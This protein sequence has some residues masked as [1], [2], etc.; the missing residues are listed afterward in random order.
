MSLTLT[1]G[2]VDKTSTFYLPGSTGDVTFSFIPGTRGS[3]RLKVYDVLGAAGYRPAIDDTLTLADGATTVFSGRIDDVDEQPLTDLDTG[4]VT[5]LTASDWSAV[6]G[7]VSY[8]VTYAAGSTLKA[9][10]TDLVTNKLSAFG[11]TLD[12]AQ[13][14]GPTFSTAVTFSTNVTVNEILNR[15]TALT[16]WLWR[17]TPTKTL[18]MIAPAATSC[19]Y[20]LSDADTDGVLG[21][22]SYRQSRALNYANTIVLTC[23]TAKQVLK[24]EP[25]TGDGVASSWTLTYAA[26]TDAGGFIVSRGYVT[27][28]GVNKTVG[29]YG[30]T[31]VSYQ[32][33]ASNNTLYRTAGPL[34]AGV[35]ISF[36]H[37]VQ[38]PFTVTYAN[39]AEVTAHGTY[40]GHYDAPDI[41]DYTEG[42]TMATALARQTITQPKIVTVKT[43]KGI[44]YPGQSIALTFAERNLSGTFMITGVDVSSAEDGSLEYTL[45]CVSGAELATSWLDFY[46]ETSTGTGSG[47]GGTVSGGA[48]V[49][50]GVAGSGTAGKL[51]KWATSSSLTDSIVSES[52]TTATVAGTLAATTFSGSGASLTSV[53]AGQLTGTIPAATL[54]GRSLA[55]L[56]TRS[57]GDLSSGNLAYARMP[58]GAG[59]W[60]A[61]PTISGTLTVS[62]ISASGD[63][64]LS[65]AGVIAA[66]SIIP[67]LTDTYDLGRYDRLWNQSYISQMN[68]LVFAKTT[69]TL[70]GGYSSIGKNA[71]SFA[72]DVA[73]AATTIDF[74][75]AMTVGDFVLV[76]AHDTGGTIKAEYLQ[77]GT[78]VSGTTYNVT[79]DLAAA[80]VTDP[81]WASGTPY[82]VLGTTNDGRI[83]LFAYDGK[84]RIVFTQQGATYNAQSDRGIIGNLNSYFGYAT[85]VYG[86]AFGDAAAANITIDPTNGFRVR[87]G[88]TTY[89][90][91][92]SSVFTV[93]NPSGKRIGWDGT[94]LTLVSDYVT[95][96]N[97]G[98]ALAPD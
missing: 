87:Q 75:Q 84:P 42:V 18:L 35:A 40:E 2:G 16:G 13:A 56:G 65:P 41:E 21:V 48:T 73:S 52:G 70:F 50:S 66:K 78:L 90:Q 91:L 67:A 60:S 62:T 33:R 45:T 51:A 12:A 97:T 34:G 86:A 93:G 37:Q 68:A 19:G 55:D 24:D 39:S 54:A 27:E 38:L 57:A 31:S 98:I 79:R 15:F 25:F 83:D 85:D 26:V 4:V 61:D 23:G 81:A 30:D 94:N 9:A 49:T 71:G 1:I 29:V 63:L 58:S 44:A 59:T 92:A 72:A 80:H 8:N 96:D 77:V 89:A 36:G 95:L 20:S 74:G 53:P 3:L 10:L 22:V 64:A 5:A 43:T 11:I 82:L 7:Q 69:Q 14:T 46:K 28:A 32:W 88:T 76:R 6:C 17:I 47:A